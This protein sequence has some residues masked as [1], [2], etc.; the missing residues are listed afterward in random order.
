MEAKRCAAPIGELE[1]QTSTR[2]N[3]CRSVGRLEGKDL[4]TSSLVRF[5][6]LVTGY[7]IAEVGARLAP[8]YLGQS[9]I[10]KRQ[11]ASTFLHETSIVDPYSG[12]ARPTA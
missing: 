2:S 5:D 6:R 11:T 7:V 4:Y 12:T 8:Q 10:S 9:W 3:V 1:Q